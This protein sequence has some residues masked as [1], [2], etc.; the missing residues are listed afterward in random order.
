[1]MLAFQYVAVPW[2]AR[3]RSPVGR[4]E[5]VER[6]VTDPG[7]V[8]V[9]FPRNCDSVAFFAGRSDFDAVRSKDVNQLI[10][11]MHHRPR[12]VVLFTHRHAFEAFKHALPDSLAVTES[13]SLKR[14]AVPVIDKLIGDTPWGLADVAV[15]EPAPQ[16]RA[17]QP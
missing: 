11:D 7:A 4:P 6:F 2:Y 10:V 13:V 5:L 8:V 3:E 1:V 9:A 15:I 12:T 16:A 14:K 17:Q